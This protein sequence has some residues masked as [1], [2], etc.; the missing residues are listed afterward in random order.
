MEPG[1]TILYVAL[2]G[3]FRAVF[4][5]G[6]SK[7]DLCSGPEN[8]IR[9]RNQFFIGVKPSALSE[10]KKGLRPLRLWQRSSKE[11]RRGKD[12]GVGVGLPGLSLSLVQQRTEVEDRVESLN[13]QDYFRTL[14]ASIICCAVFCDSPNILIITSCLIVTYFHTYT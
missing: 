12:I 13:R 5:R 1:L 6:L 9:P 8:K 11:G 10:L 4:S 7:P 3:P 14:N 2:C